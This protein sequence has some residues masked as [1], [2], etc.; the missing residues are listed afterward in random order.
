MAAWLAAMALTALFA[1]RG[2]TLIHF[3]MQ[4][5][6]LLLILLTIA[7]IVSITFALSPLPGSGRRFELVSGVWT[8]LMYL[9]LGVIPLLIRFFEKGL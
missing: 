4:V 1:W 6:I 7:V 2:A 3:A 5:G 8:L 9:S